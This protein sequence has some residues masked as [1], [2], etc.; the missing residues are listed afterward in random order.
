MADPLFSL[1][2]PKK[3]FQAISTDLRRSVE[4]AWN[5]PKFEKVFKKTKKQ[6]DGQ[7]TRQK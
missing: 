6:F 3:V 4:I 1:G 2:R 7:K 5:I